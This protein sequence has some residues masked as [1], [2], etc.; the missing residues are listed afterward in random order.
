MEKHI[1]EPP[2]NKPFYTR[3]EMLE[4]AHIRS[5]SLSD[6][7][8]TDLIEDGLINGPCKNG[9]PGGGSEAVWPQEQLDLL[10]TVLK[11]QQDLDQQAGHHIYARKLLCNI[12]VCVWLYWGEAYIPLHQVKRAMVTWARA[13]R[14]SPK[15][16]AKQSARHLTRLSAS[17]R[18]DRNDKEV[19]IKRIITLATSGESLKD[20][21]VKD[22]LYLLKD[23]ID[24]E[25]IGEARGPARAKLSA[26][27]VVGLIHAR[28]IAINHLS[29][30]SGEISII[31]D[32]IWHWAR[33]THLFVSQL[34]KQTQPEYASDPTLDSVMKGLFEPLN[35]SEML[36]N[37][38][39]HL[40]A[41]LGL[42]I[43]D[44]PLPGLPPFLQPQV[45]KTGE[46]TS[47][48]RTYVLVSPLFLPDGSRYTYP[49]IEV[50]IINNSL[51]A[52]F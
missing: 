24:P 18:S 34:Y 25:D 1:I 43:L 48:I 14:R 39:G 11:K 29:A 15:S 36:N 26:E 21:E 51:Q 47:R 13:Y 42:G 16:K 49:S 12:P 30:Q 33:T 4:Q 20:N 3:A 22:F 38:C 46:I 32:T 6:R 41:V 10:L 52:T 9:L 31:P 17:P 37:A 19:L 2:A 45:W 40:L 27:A 8:L 50:E 28:L 35:M 5:L 44:E 7:H 23:V